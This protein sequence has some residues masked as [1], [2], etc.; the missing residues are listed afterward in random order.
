MRAVKLLT[1]KDSKRKCI[2]AGVREKS[3]P[4]LKKDYL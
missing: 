3:V 1:T 2:S 4:P